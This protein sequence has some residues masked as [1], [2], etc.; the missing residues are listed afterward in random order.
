MKL[1]HLLVTCLIGS[2]AVASPPRADA[3]AAEATTKA[4]PALELGMTPEQIMAAIGKPQ[5]VKPMPSAEGKA[6]VWTYRRVL[7]REVVQVAA[8]TRDVPVYLGAFSSQ[9]QERG[10]GDA[11]PGT[12][13]EFIYNQVRRTKYQVTALLVFE[14]QLTSAKQWVEVK[15]DVVY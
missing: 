2:F 15:D 6:E 8:S 9:L 14:G 1:R 11:G 3:G 13:K 7:H 12:A 5:E 4:K 10:I